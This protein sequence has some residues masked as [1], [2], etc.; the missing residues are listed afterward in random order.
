[1]TVR[2]KYIVFEGLDGSGKTSQVA[3][4]EDWLKGLG[5]PVQ[6]VSE[7]YTPE[8]FPV[9]VRDL[10]AADCRLDRLS[11]EYLFQASRVEHLKNVEAALASG[12]HVVSDRSYISGQVY[13]EAAGLNGTLLAELSRA[14]PLK[15]DFLIYLDIT[16]EKAMDRIL[17]RGENLTRDETLEN[18]TRVRQIYTHVISEETTANQ[19]Q[20][21]RVDGGGN[22]LQ[23]AFAVRAS[24]D[25]FLDYA[26]D[27]E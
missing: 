6:L 18:L 8:S 5:G 19:M 26:E 14:V 27:Q 1:M 3:L 22:K 21:A 15:P 10:L 2:G 9:N 20:W 11:I 23:V 16:P 12:T 17:G 25:A 24:V 7:P 13:A 4:L